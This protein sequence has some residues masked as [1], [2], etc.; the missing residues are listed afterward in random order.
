MLA[1]LNIAA[2]HTLVIDEG[3]EIVTQTLAGVTTDAYGQ[4][5]YQAAH[6]SPYLLDL[7]EGLTRLRIAGQHLNAHYRVLSSRPAPRPPTPRR[8]TGRGGHG[9]SPE[10][11]GPCGGG[12]AGITEAPS[13]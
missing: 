7:A 10:T 3:R 11:P 12:R 1:N 9:A 5:T 2:G 4:L 8:P 13:G 6:A